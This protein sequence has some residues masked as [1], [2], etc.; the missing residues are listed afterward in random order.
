ML[1]ENRPVVNKNLN[2]KAAAP[3]MTAKPTH[4][5]MNRPRSDRDVLDPTNPLARILDLAVDSI[6]SV[7][8]HQSILLFNQGAQKLFG[9]SAEEVCGKPLDMLLPASSVGVHRERSK[10]V[11]SAWKAGNRRE[12]LGRRKDGSEFAAEA[13]LSKIDIDGRT[14]FTVSLQETT[15]QSLAEDRLRAA[16][17]EKEVLLEEIHHRVKNN[18]QVIASLLGLQAR[19]IRDL[20]TRAKFG[21]SR[22]RI[23]AMAILH[24]ILYESSSLAEIDFAD[25]IHRV[26]KH[27]ARSFGTAGRIRLKVRL[28]PLH[29]HRDVALPCGLI[30]N[31]L[32]SNAFKYAFPGEKS[33]EVRIEL[34]RETNG[35]V[36]L[37]VGDTGVGLPRDLDWETSPTLGL[38]LVRT[39]ALQI[40]ANVGTNNSGEGAV[41]SITFRDSLPV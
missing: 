39:L 31:E 34:W 29:C 33:G 9:Y 13:S 35:T 3:T 4:P 22:H 5:K 17:R 10:T 20:A 25:Y 40:E 6:V 15:R 1:P 21:E 38:R 32:L 24:E 11:D 19:S 41:F 18:L 23:Q 16:L 7:D 28:Q 2:V 30:V 27:L 36:H 8:R 37:L 26:A 12:I 14:V